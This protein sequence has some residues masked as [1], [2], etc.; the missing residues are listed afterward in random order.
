MPDVYLSQWRERA[1]LADKSRRLSDETLGELRSSGLLNLVCPR[2]AK[3]LKPG[4]PALVRSSR[5]AARA[6]AS[7][8]WLISLVG[9]HAAIAARLN[10]SFEAK[11]YDG[12][13]TQLFAS[14]SAGPDSRLS[15]EPGG[16]RVSGRWRFS[17]GIEH[18]T[19][20][21]LNAPCA[22][23]PTADASERFL[24]V[25]A[26]QD[27]T[28]LD[29]WDSIGMRATGSHDVVTSE[30][31]VPHH[32]VFPLQEVFGARPAGAGSDY[33]YSVPIV[34]FITTSIIGPLLGCAEGAY[35]LH[36]QALA[37]QTTP[38]SAVALERVAHSGAQLTAASAL[39][40]SL[41]NRLDESGQ[42]LRSLS[43]SQLSALK[44]DRSYLARQCVEAVHRLVEHSGA[45]LMTTGNPL[46]RHWR[47][48]QTMAAHRDVHWDSAMLASAASALH[49]PFSLKSLTGDD[50]VCSQQ[51]R[52]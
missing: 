38:P 14:A 3:P 12:G 9:G 43:E 23:P 2:R 5:I 48:L 33:L 4:W 25:V 32:E 30:L 17:S 18:A 8:G 42:A 46:H 10:P 52:Y 34:P 15:I 16:M 51:S 19:W 28:V 44:R 31:L 35:D 27:V 11:L 37:Q 21:I 6:C 29:S 50:D 7:T 40:D 45:S 20:L 41:V 22:N 26:K 1:A 36:L 47:D 49:P 39:F 13:T 24:V